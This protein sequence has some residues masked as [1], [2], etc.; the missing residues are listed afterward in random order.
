MGKHGVYILKTFIALLLLFLNLFAS[1]L[2]IEKKIYKTIIYSLFPHKEIIKVWS[3]D[4]RKKSF[5]ISIQNITI[6]KNP[7]NADILI[8]NKPLKHI[9]NK[10]IFITNYPILKKYKDIAIGGF[11]WQ[12]GRPNIIFLEKNLKRFHLNLPQSMQEYIEEDL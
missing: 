5:L 2:E 7:K 11:Y 12:K 10:I 3:D 9:P 1:N 4:K 6:V 8:I